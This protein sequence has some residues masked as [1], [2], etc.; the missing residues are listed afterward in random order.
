[1]TIPLTSTNARWRSRKLLSVRSGRCGS[2]L[3]RAISRSGTPTRPATIRRSTRPIN[4]TLARNG[5]LREAD[6]EHIYETYISPSRFTER[7]DHVGSQVMDEIEQVMA[8]ID[9]AA[10]TAV[11]LHARTSPT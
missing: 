4:E 10:G 8:M 9:A 2:R 3:P 7:I 11:E 5:T 1:M 6:V